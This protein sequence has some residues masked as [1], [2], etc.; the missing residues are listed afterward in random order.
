MFADLGVM[1]DAATSD[2]NGK[3][4]ILGI[5]DQINARNF[6]AV[7]PQC[8]VV[9][10]IIFDKGEEVHNKFK[11]LFLDENKK[12]FLPT[13]EAKS[14]DGV[15][16]YK[17]RQVFNLILGISNLKIPVSGDYEIELFFGGTLLK[18]IDLRAR[19]ILPSES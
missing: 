5:F 4:N 19:K 14:N 11:L 3:L 1:C 2:G 8:S 18:K 17:D 7:H 10:K 15:V 9:F 12:Q 16:Q 6:P 13:I